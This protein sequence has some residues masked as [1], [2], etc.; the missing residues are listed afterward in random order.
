MA[1]VSYIC[2]SSQVIQSI[3]YT[4]CILNDCFGSNEVQKKT[5]LIRKLKDMLF[6]SVAF[7]VAMFVGLTFWG[8]YAVDRELVFPKALDPYFPVWLN[9]V[10]HTN[11][12]IFI[13]IEMITSFREYPKQ[14]IGL[15][16][17]T[18]FMLSYLVWM[19]VV[20]YKTDVWVYPV[21]AVLNTPLR[22]C[23]FLVLL[24]LSVT[25]YKLGDFINTKVWAKQIKHVKKA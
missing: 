20:Y 16:I 18:G 2:M 13:L 14:K 5:P 3:F 6:T 25:L 4:I 24:G 23:F 22:I 21:M 1:V 17:L 19:H 15:S 9:H 7:P 8:L 12:M 10:M 11:I